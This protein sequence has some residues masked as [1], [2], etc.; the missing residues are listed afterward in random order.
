MVAFI[1]LFNPILKILMPSSK[2]TVEIKPVAVKFDAARIERAVKE[3]LI[4]IGENPDREGLLDT[5][6]RVARMYKEIF[7]GLRED[8][9]IHT[10][11]FFSEHYNEIVLVRDISFNSTCEHH[12][13]PFIGNVHIGYI[14][15]GKVI[16]LS[17]L[18][19]VV[20]VLSHRPQVQERLT[21]EIAEHL[22]TQLKAK[23]VAV[24]I[25]AVHTC[26]TVRGVKKPGA[27]CITSALRGMF[28]KNPSSRAEI[29]SLIGI[30][31]K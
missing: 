16:G 25:E 11:K 20:E 5:P 24:V 26:M 15:D 3:I 8:P 2:K 28:L 22:S 12:L 10:K 19:R 17:K 23:G 30:G 31:K 14:P 1:F 9:D 21:E 29:F 7:S 13:M 18:A 27:T 4:A 6:A